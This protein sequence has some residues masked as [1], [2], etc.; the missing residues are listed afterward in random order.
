M[1]GR[2]LGAKDYANLLELA[3]KI[4]LYGF[5]VSLPLAGLGFL[6]YN[7]IGE[8]FSSNAEVLET[9][10]SIFFLVLVGLPFNTM[11][12]V[13]D[14]LYKGMGEMK[15]LRNVLLAATG[16][17]FIPLLY[18]GL[19]MGWGIYSIWIAFLGWMFIRGSALG[20]HFW[21]RY[22]PLAQPH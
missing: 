3:K 2:F 17:G 18:F 22:R 10:A 12:F 20:I 5:L 15:F 9:F 19:E 6:F 1:G 7:S 14:G 16:L 21:K 8:L 13:Y 11:A 4:L